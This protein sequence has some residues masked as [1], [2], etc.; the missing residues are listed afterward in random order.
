VLPGLPATLGGLTNSLT[1]VGNSILPGLLNA[2]AVSGPC[3]TGIVGPYDALVY[4]TSINLQSLVGGWL[5]DPVPLLR[6]V[7][8]NQMS[9]GQTIATALQTGDFEPVAAIPGH[10]GQNIANLV[11]TLMDTDVTSSLVV[12]SLTVPTDVTLDNVVGQSLVFGAARCRRPPRW[13]RRVT[14]RRRLRRP[15]RPGTPR[16]PSPPSSMHPP[17]SRTASSTA[18]RQ[19][20]T[21]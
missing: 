13:T 18:R 14:A 20:R 3:F 5:A 6:Q 4:N 17:S 9:Y 1:G 8:T 11:A 2:Q 12:Q 15:S 19:P 16:R 10:I 7:V 21:R